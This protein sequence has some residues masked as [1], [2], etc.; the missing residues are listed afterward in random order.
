MGFHKNLRK[1]ITKCQQELDDILY[2]TLEELDRI[3]NEILKKLEVEE[4]CPE[5]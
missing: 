2:L 3:T 1:R 4:E 5:Q